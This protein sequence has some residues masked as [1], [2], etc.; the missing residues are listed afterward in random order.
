M[1]NIAILDDDKTALMIS[2]GSIEQFIQ[3]RNIQCSIDTFSD[4]YLFIQAVKINNYTV[5]I[6]DI[7]LQES[8]GIE[9]GKQVKEINPQIDIIYLSQREDLVFDTLYLHPFGFI[10]KSKI[11]QDFPSVFQLYLDTRMNTADDNSKLVVTSKNSVINIDI[12]EIMYVEG[13]KNYQTIYLKDGTMMDVRLSMGDLETNLSK[14]GFIRIHKGYLVNYIYIRKIVKN[15]VILLNNK[16]L[17]L[18]RKRKDE[19]MEQYLK[20]SRAN[21]FIKM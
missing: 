16:I 2:K 1:L 8:N 10:R 6:L 5:V 9:V 19:I 4:A 18:A 3:N 12:N 20:V 17:P 15:D 13:N 21:K 11:I 7:D 14:K